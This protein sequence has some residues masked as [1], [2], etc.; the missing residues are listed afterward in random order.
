MK[1]KSWNQFIRKKETNFLRALILGGPLIEN[2]QIVRGVEIL[3]HRTGLL[4]KRCQTIL[5]LKQIHVSC[6]SS[7]ML[8]LYL[9]LAQKPINYFYYQ[10]C[11]VH[12]RTYAYAYSWNLEKNI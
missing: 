10:E 2:A 6:K 12:V 8:P 1:V 5:R 11:S 9:S 7:K 4:W 3:R